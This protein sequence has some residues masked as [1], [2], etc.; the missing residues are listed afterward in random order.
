M[1]TLAY[2]QINRIG[3]NGEKKKNCLKEKKKKPIN[4]K[5]IKKKNKPFARWKDH[6]FNLVN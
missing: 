6:E 5:L 4:Q 2:S 3:I 1:Q